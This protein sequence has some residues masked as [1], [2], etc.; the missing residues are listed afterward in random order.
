[1]YIV[2]TPI[3]NLGDI[4]QRALDVLAAADMVLC[5]DTRVTGKLLVHF[6]I[7]ART[8]A[9][10]DHNENDAYPQMLA[11]LQ[12]GKTLALVSDAGTPL[13]SDPGYRLVSEAA[14]LGIKVIPIPGA[15]SVTA[16]LSV[17]GL[18]TD[19]FYFAGFLPAKDAARRSAIAELG[20]VPGTL[21]LLESVHR[22]PESLAA[23]SEILGAREATIARELTKL[24]EE[25]RRGTLQELAAHYAQT[26]DPKGE[27]VIVIGPAPAQEGTA[28][29]VDALLREALK[30]CSV[31]DAAAEVAKL[32]GLPRQEL[33]SR[34]LALKVKP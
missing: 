27:V 17:S 18:P 11:A 34:A 32:T 30:E 25:L 22:L 23:L 20:A 16:A 6:G 31:K 4:T 12:A 13:I 26:G 5:E 28:L 8:V 21:V 7:K 1:L 19:R 2:A 9:Y 33:Y 3:G 10:H 29:D 15:S 24:Y 14:K